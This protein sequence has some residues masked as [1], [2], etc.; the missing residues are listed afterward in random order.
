MDNNDLTDFKNEV[1]K[2]IRQIEQKIMTEISINNSDINSNYD[3]YNEKIDIIMEN[4]KKMI[5]SVLSQ[6]INFAKIV[7]L[8]KFKYKVDG[9]LTTHEMRITK[10]LGDIDK[11]KN[12]LDKTLSDNLYI[13]GFIGPSC[14]YKTVSEYLSILNQDFCKFKNEKEISQK[15]EKENRL[16]Y[17]NL[18]KSMAS[19]VDNSFQRSKDY[20]ENRQKDFI[21]IIDNKI[22]KFE[23]KNMEVRMQTCKMAMDMEQKIN[24]KNKEIE[25]LLQMKNDI[26]E[27]TD[28]KIIELKEIIEEKSKINDLSNNNM[29]KLEDKLNKLDIKILNIEQKIKKMGINSNFGFNKNLK[30]IRI[31]SNSNLNFRIIREKLDSEGETKIKNSNEIIKYTPPNTNKDNNKKRSS[32]IINYE[33]GESMNISL[34]KKVR[35]NYSCFGDDTKIENESK[36]L[37]KEVFKKEDKNFKG[38]SSYKTKNFDFDSVVLN[39]YRTNGGNKEPSKQEDSRIKYKNNNNSIENRGASEKEKSLSE[40]ELYGIQKHNKKIRKQVMIRN[41]L[42]G[43]SES[44]CEDSK[45]QKTE[46]KKQGVE[47]IKHHLPNI[48]I[49]FKSINFNINECINESNTLIETQDKNNDNAYSFQKLSRKDSSNKKERKKKLLLQGIVNEAPLRLAPAFGRT[50]YTLNTNDKIKE[51]FNRTYYSKRSRSKNNKNEGLNLGIFHSKK[52]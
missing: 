37:G 17:D 29:A 26:I 14:Q 22:L 12:R 35:N 44:I 3:K 25:R 50:A 28:K 34:K 18:M 49:S 43:P 19:L 5:D 8:E 41:L 11:L 6:K 39:S 2:T 1:F 7:E 38:N 48:G 45:F 40:A 21:N 27:M 33:Q 32:E 46:Q 20:V 24:E 13:P 15:I 4:N 52:S 42:S 16:K 31:N 30:E 51:N 47:Q 23:E 36:P 10:C 9:I